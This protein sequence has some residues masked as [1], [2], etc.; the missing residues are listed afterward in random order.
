MSTAIE[1][2]ITRY[3]REMSH[4]EIAHTLGCSTTDV[5][6]YICKVGN[7]RKEHVAIGTDRLVKLLGMRA[8]GAKL[9]DIALVVGIHPKTITNYCNRYGLNRVVLKSQRE[10]KVW[11][12]IAEAKSYTDFRVNYQTEYG[13]AY[14]LDM[15]DEVKRTFEC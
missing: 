8:K 3:Q 12:A 5:I 7:K 9:K 10:E 14:R 15:L 13:Y 11:E 6:K 1:N 2:V 4:E